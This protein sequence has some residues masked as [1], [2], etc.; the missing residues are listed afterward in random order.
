[1]SETPAGLNG[2]GPDAAEPG[3]PGAAALGATER[4][5]QLASRYA[6]EWVAVSQ[7]WSHLYAHGAS[8]LAGCAGATA[9]GA[10]N[11]LIARLA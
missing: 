5:R 7:D 4:R 3:S 10:R 11:A 6:G 8:Y 1:M 2:D 9:R